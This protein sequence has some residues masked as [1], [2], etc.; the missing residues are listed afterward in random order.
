VS[1]FQGG[2]VLLTGRNCS[3]QHGQ[4][5]GPG[6]FS[7]PSSPETGVTFTSDAN[8]SIETTGKNLKVNGVF[9]PHSTL[10]LPFP[11][12]AVVLRPRVALHL[13]DPDHG[14]E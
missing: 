13:D 3:T 12:P 2:N 4:T 9:H 14:H 6:E 5:C 11:V 8:T 7:N 10:D 1:S